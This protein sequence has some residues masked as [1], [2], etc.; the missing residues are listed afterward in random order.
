M[1][2]YFS[3]WG[4]GR[5]REQHA[6]SSRSRALD[7]MNVHLHG[8]PADFTILGSRHA[9]SG[10]RIQSEQEN[11]TA[12]GPA[13]EL[14]GHPRMTRQ[15]LARKL[16]NAARSTDYSEH[17]RL[18]L[19]AAADPSN[20]HNSWSARHFEVDHV[21]SKGKLSS[22][23]EESKHSGYEIVI[24]NHGDQPGQAEKRTRSRTSFDNA[25]QWMDMGEQEQLGASKLEEL[26]RQLGAA[27]HHIVQ[28]EAENA[29]VQKIS[30]QRHCELKIKD[31]ENTALKNDNVAVKKH[32]ESC[33]EQIFH[34]QP[35]QHLS[36]ADIASRYKDLYIHISD[37]LFEN[38]AD[39]A[40][41]VIWLA[42]AVMAYDQYD[43][44]YQHLPDTEV[45]LVYEYPRLDGLLLTKVLLGFLSFE[46]IKDISAGLPEDVK[47]FLAEVTN[48]MLELTPKRG[49]RHHLRTLNPS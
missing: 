35:K 9:P 21:Q 19:N 48:A 25:K 24:P 41:T 29:T 40:T 37:T 31:K 17:E 13:S 43:L 42:R 49:K 12:M 4:D 44:F 39:L 11:I 16:Q 33:K 28:L 34:L 30:D 26:Q 15:M 8:D 27:L 6:S 7:Q 14:N 2:H 20:E 22:T 1:A 46:F 47:E 38:F 5:S 3:F 32:L 10:A 18:P 45:G 23:E 36:D